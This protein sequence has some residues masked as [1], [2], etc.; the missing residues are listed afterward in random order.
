MKGTLQPAR[1]HMG[2]VKASG[3]CEHARGV[4]ALHSSQV[5]E[6]VGEAAPMDSGS[7]GPR[8][9]PP[10]ATSQTKIM[11]LS[12]KRPKDSIDAIYSMYCKHEFTVSDSAQPA[13]AL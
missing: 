10:A 9:K 3:Y 8:E 13:T 12:L 4:V 6:G 5:A 7:Q 11:V 1:F 2:I